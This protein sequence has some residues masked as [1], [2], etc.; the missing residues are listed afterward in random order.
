MGEVIETAAADAAVLVEAGFPALMVENWGDAPFHA[1]SVPP[2]T[3]AAMTLAAEAVGGQGVPFGV[4]VLRNDPLTALGIAAAT[5]AALIR[6]NIL[7]GVMYTDQGAITGQAAEVMRS[8]AALCPDVEVWADVMVKHATPPPGLDA[9][10]SAEDTVH[11]GLA[12]AV[13]V[14]GSGTGAEPDLAESKTIADAVPGTRVVTRLRSHSR[15]PGV[16]VVGRRLFDRGLS[17]QVRRQR[18]QSARPSTMQRLRRGGRRPRD[19]VSVES[20]RTDG[21]LRITLSDPD[22]RN[23]ITGEEMLDSLLDALDDAE[24]APDIAVVV[25][26]AKGPAFSSGWE[27]QGH[28]GA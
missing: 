5:G 13:I 20:S 11:R 15:Q 4:N 16:D 3:V 2:E 6:V 14:S 19:V 26:D 23:A 28:G 18:R 10:Q 27:R 24:K 22:T 12:D 7:T 21:V 17:Y 8:R 9:A 25:I 1:G